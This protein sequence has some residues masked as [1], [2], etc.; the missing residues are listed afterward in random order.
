MG[1]SKA[2]ATFD[3]LLDE[4]RDIGEMWAGPD[5]GV[6]DPDDTMEAGANDGRWSTGIHAVLNDLDVDVE[7]GNYEITVG[8]EQTGRNRLP[9]PPG[10]GRITTRHYF[11]W[12][13]SAAASQT[14]H[15]PLSITAVNP[16]PPPPRWDDDRVAAALRRV[17][18]HVRSKTLDAPVPEGGLPSWVSTVPNQFPTPEKP[19]TLGFAAAD[20]AYSMT[21]FALGPDEALVI[22]GRWPDCRFANV[23]LW[24]RFGQMF[25]YVNRPVSR[26][27]ANTVLEADGSFRMILAHQDPGLPNWLDTEG[28]ASGS[29]FWRF[30]LP[31][32]EV[33]TPQVEVVPFASLT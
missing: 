16:P 6:V 11:E 4:L 10:G 32:G 14:L 13:V 19:G 23:C 9:I 26:N 15:I 27:R 17:I 25:D 20:A 30:F 7:D 18:N 21:R 29:I 5:R 3:E 33:E 31:E 8:G 2:R 28:R 12:P 22:T 1:E 24:N